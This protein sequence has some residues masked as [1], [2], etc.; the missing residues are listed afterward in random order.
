MLGTTLD[1]ESRIRSDPYNP[2][3]HIALA[4]AYLED[5]DDERAR[6]IIAIKRRLPSKDPSVH[7]EWGNL[8]E[9]LGMASQARESYEQ[10]IAMN[11]ENPEYHF[12]VALLYHEKGAT[13]RAMK[14]LQKAVSLSPQNREAK[15]MLVSIYQEMGLNGSARVLKE[16]KKGED[17]ASRTFAVELTGEDTSSFLSIFRGREFGYARYQIGT[18]GSV[19]HSFVKGSLGFN[20]LLQHLKGEETFGIYPLRSNK[21]LKFSCIQI[22][23]PWRR[24]VDNVKNSGFLTLL[25]DKVHHYARTLVEKAR[26]DGVPAYLEDPGGR[27]R[28]VWFF[29]DEFIPFELAERFL[30]AILDKVRAPFVDITVA[31]ILGL[32]GGGI[33]LVEHPIMLPLGINPQT[34][35]RCFLIDEYGDPCGDQLLQVKKIR[36]IG[37]ENIRHF[38]KTPER[39]FSVFHSQTSSDSLQ[40]LLSHCPVIEEIVRKAHSG[41]ILKEE[42]KIVIF[43][44][45]GFFRDGF[46]S[47]HTVLEPCP[48][49]R[50]KRVERM[51]SRLK[52]NPISCPKIRHLLPDLTSYAKCDCSFQIP[53]GAYPSPLLHTKLQEKGEG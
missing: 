8:C 37:R 46:K 27:S 18:A 49:Y 45:L 31:P 33:G 12:R 29:F 9:E 36:T 43:F 21:T 34:G 53:E 17:F 50:P 23:I 52:S 41:R 25:E 28:R 11:P 5:G 35:K 42:E 44:T 16:E 13:E 1:I 10:A 14:H 26:D 6:K 38:I 20:E 47:L 22:G 30:N 40:R 3:H 15:Q 19:G 39:P 32:K 2:V 4:R 24:V 7:F 51:G 48:D